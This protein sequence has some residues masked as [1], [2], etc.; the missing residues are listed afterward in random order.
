MT[1]SI[2]GFL[3]SGERVSF[4]PLGSVA[5]LFRASEMRRHGYTLL[6]LTETATGEVLEIER[7][8][9]GNSMAIH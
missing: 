6:T 9:R 8:M 2:E 5:V 3:P 1:Y 4:G 7:F